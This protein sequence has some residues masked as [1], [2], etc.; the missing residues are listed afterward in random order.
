MLDRRRTGS[1]NRPN[2]KLCVT[3]RELFEVRC[4][5]RFGWTRTQIGGG[6]GKNLLAVLFNIFSRDVC[7]FA[8]DAFI[9]GCAGGGAQD[10]RI[11]EQSG[12]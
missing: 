9:F 8:R 3:D 12:Q 2:G 6:S 7:Q 1:L 11:D 4:N 5:Q 10:E